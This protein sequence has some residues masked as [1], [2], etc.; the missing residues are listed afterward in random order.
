[1]GIGQRKRVTLT[2]IAVTQDDNGRNIESFGDTYKV[3]AEVSNPSGF[4]QYLNGQTNLGKT[5]DFKLRFR[6]DKHPGADWKIIYEGKEWTV[7]EI[8]RKDEKNFYW[9]VT[10]SSNV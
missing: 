4:R 2:T 6:F 9:F 7:K 10:A 3:W 1:M 5:K 8:Q